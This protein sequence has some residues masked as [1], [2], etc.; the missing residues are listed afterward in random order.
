VMFW[1]QLSFVMN[2]LNVFLVLLLLL[3]LLLL[4]YYSCW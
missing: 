3:L 2:L 4:L 1:V